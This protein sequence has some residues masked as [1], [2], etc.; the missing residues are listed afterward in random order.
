MGDDPVLLG[1]VN[2]NGVINIID[3]TL[4]ISYVISM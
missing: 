2:G 4:L 3:V 1:D